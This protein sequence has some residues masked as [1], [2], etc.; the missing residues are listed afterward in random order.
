MREDVK[1]ALD[2]G[3]EYIPYWFEDYQKYLEDIDIGEPEEVLTDT[4]EPRKNCITTVM[5]MPYPA[6]MGKPY[7]QWANGFKPIG[8]PFV[9]RHVIKGMDLAVLGKG[10][11]PTQ[12]LIFSQEGKLDTAI[13]LDRMVYSDIPEEYMAILTSDTVDNILLTAQ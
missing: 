13:T 2:S 7:C 5:V 11:V 4:S 1:D 6:V 12:L 9:I 10:D 3:Y 8:Y